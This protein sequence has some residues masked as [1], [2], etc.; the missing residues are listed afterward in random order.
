MCLYQCEILK[1]AHLE[2]QGLFGLRQ[3]LLVVRA[4]RL[5][6]AGNLALKVARRRKFGGQRSRAAGALHILAPSRKLERGRLPVGL[7]DALPLCHV[8]AGLLISARSRPSQEHW[9]ATGIIL[10]PCTCEGCEVQTVISFPTSSHPKNTRAGHC[11]MDCQDRDS[12][13][14]G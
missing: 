7:D 10:T 9:S 14:E 3:S 8:L 4:S 13:W 12:Y 1:G 11:Q 2:R 5:Q 6:H